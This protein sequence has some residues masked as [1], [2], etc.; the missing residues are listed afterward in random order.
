[1]SKYWQGA[2]KLPELSRCL[3]SWRSSVLA[4]QRPYDRFLIVLNVITAL[5]RGPV[6]RGH[7]YQACACIRAT[8]LAAAVGGTVQARSNKLFGVFI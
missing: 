5:S 6:S 1:V 3:L 2:G 8:S 7:L 4:V